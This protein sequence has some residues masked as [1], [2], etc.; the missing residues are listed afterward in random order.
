[1]SIRKRP[2]ILQWTVD[3]DLGEN[4]LSGVKG[5]ALWAVCKCTRVCSVCVCSGECVCSHVCVCAQGQWSQW[6]LSQQ[7]IRTEDNLKGRR[8]MYCGPRGM[9]LKES[10]LL[11]FLSK[12]GRLSMRK[13]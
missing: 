12:G 9:A 1:M 5:A 2:Q 4:S 3:N 8:A 7:R 6:E 13:T 10:L 11:V